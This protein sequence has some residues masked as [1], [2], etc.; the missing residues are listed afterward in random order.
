MLESYLL[1]R[2][3][4][5]AAIWAVLYASDYYLTIWGAKLREAQDVL[6]TEGSYELNPFFQKDVDRKRLVGRAFLIW[7]ILGA[8]VLVGAGYLV[9]E[10]RKAYG[11]IAGMFVLPH[12]CV[13]RRHVSN[14]VLLKE[15]LRPESGVSGHLKVKRHVA[16]RECGYELGMYAFT[17]IVLFAVTDSY[18]LLGGAFMLALMSR[19]QFIYSKRAKLKPTPVPQDTAD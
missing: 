10:P 15:V 6:A 8:V 2:P 16:H 18:I 9:D 3:W 19:R 7:L 11:F 14:I 13:L 12:L 5:V 1:S 17:A 4:L